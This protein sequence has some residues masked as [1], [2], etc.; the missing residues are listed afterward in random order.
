MSSFCL[1]EYSTMAR[2]YKMPITFDLIFFILLISLITF[3]KNKK[4]I[5]ILNWTQ[6][7]GLYINKTELN[8]QNTFLHNNII[9]DIF[10]SFNEH[11]CELFLVPHSTIHSTID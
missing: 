3:V 8:K 1:T 5:K 4:F 6:P 7:L 9:T 10:F 2:T 11:I